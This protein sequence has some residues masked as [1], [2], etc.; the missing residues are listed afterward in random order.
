MIDGEEVRFNRQDFIGIC[1]ENYLPDWA[2]EK[3]SELQPN[4][5]PEGGPQPVMKGL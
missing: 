1:D 2:K 4:H 5:E 3:L